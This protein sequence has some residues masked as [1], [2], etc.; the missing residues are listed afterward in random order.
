MNKRFATTAY[1]TAAVMAAAPSVAQAPERGV[2]FEASAR[3]TYDSNVYRGRPGFASG[4]SSDVIFSP[5]VSVA[6]NVPLGRQTF[7]AKG[8]AAYDFYA[9][10]DRLNRERI[11]ADGGVVSRISR[12]EVNLNAGYSRGRSD[13]LAFDIAVDDDPENVFT[14]G[15]LGVSAAC[16]SVVGVTPTA[17]YRRTR[18]DNSSGAR[19]TLDSDTDTYTAGLSYRRPTLGAVTV[20]GSRSE[21]TYRNASSPAGFETNSLGGRFERQVAPRLRGMIELAQTKVESKTPG[22]KEFSGLTYG[23]AL[24]ARVGPRLTADLTYDKRIE[25]SQRI[26]AQYSVR[27]GAALRVNYSAGSRVILS[28]G[29]SRDKLR[30]EGGPVPALFPRDETLDAVFASA[31]YRMGRR[32]ALIGDVRHD[33]READTAAFDYSGTRASVTAALTF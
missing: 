2:Q 10:N 17:S 6:A 12:C 14:R 1:A 23:G 5:G 7:Y 19:S 32:W 8:G 11:F 27:E 25:P 33:R 28:G 22:T 20:F 13:V 26:G 4:E 31:R 9:E 24:T 21:T 16:P 3:T 15:T 30:S 29:V 18:T